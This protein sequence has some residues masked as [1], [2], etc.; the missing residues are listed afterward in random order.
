MLPNSTWHITHSGSAY[1]G[2]RIFQWP[3]SIYI[4]LPN[5]SIQNHLCVC[6][7]GIASVWK[8]YFS[9]VNDVND[10]SNDNSRN[11]E[12]IWNAWNYPCLCTWIVMGD[13]KKISSDPHACITTMVDIVMR[14]VIWMQMCTNP[15]VLCW[16]CIRRLQSHKLTFTFTF[17]LQ[18]KPTGAPSST[19]KLSVLHAEMLAFPSS[20]THTLTLCVSVCVRACYREISSS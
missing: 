13:F 1:H 11:S 19:S 15:C 14:N 10:D 16:C 12:S 8:F 5:A 9:V 17:A 6:V 3:V 4:G 18:F 2:Y 7:P 20:F